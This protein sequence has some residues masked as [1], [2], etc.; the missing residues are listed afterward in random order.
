MTRQDI[1][2]H[3][4]LHYKPYISEITSSNSGQG[5][6]HPD[7]FGS[8][9]MRRVRRFQEAWRGSDP[10]QAQVAGGGARNTEDYGGRTGMVV[11]MR[12]QL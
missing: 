12:L 5:R 11:R 7:V 3:T 2:K 4:Q 10:G 1:H 6:Q 8:S 9:V